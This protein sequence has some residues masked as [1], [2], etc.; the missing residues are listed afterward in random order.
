ML[1][2]SF[3]VPYEN[4]AKYPSLTETMDAISKYCEE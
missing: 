1:K 2:K 3:W 4:S